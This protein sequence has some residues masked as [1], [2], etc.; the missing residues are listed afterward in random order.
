MLVVAL[1]KPAWNPPPGNTALGVPRYSPADWLPLDGLKPS[2]S[3]PSLSRML[4]NPPFS[5]CN[6]YVPASV[7]ILIAS[8]PSSLLFGSVLTCA[9]KLAGENEPAVSKYT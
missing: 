8:R 4:E 1:T 7:V 3:L 9:V 6:Q 2:Q 5:S